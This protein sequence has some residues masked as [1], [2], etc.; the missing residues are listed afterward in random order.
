MSYA[1]LLYPREAMQ[2]QSTSSYTMHAG[3]SKGQETYLELY[4][5]QGPYYHITDDT[6][7]SVKN[8]AE[9]VCLLLVL[10]FT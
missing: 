3:F 10:E 1:I 7:A 4:K 8:L 5:K 2:F 9:Y 6:E